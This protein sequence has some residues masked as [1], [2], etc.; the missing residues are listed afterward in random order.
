MIAANNSYRISIIITLYDIKQKARIGGGDRKFSKMVEL[1]GPQNL[2][3][4]ELL[5][6]KFA[7]KA[8]LSKFSRFFGVASNFEL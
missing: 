3:I 6:P 5:G 7:K 8:F 1:L 2:K 4:V